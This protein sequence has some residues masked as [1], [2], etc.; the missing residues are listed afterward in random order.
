MCGEL[1]TAGFEK[2]TWWAS[3]QLL[4]TGTSFQAKG[5]RPTLKS[6]FLSFLSGA[7][8]GTQSLV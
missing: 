6:F 3:E 8:A 2:G 1:Q 4:E 5:G 7:E